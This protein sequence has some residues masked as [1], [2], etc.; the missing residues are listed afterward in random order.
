MAI[1][2]PY[3]YSLKLCVNIARNLIAVYA[4]GIKSLKTGQVSVMLDRSL[5]VQE[6]LKR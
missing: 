2:V 6:Q 1:R 5:M 3:P 4:I